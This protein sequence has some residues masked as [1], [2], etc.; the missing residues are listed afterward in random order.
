MSFIRF[1]CLCLILISPNILA[2][3]ANISVTE[4]SAVSV[5]P[6]NYGV[7]WDDRGTSILTRPAHG[8]ATI[9]RAADR[10]RYTPSPNY[11]GSD[12][13][14][15][16]TETFS[17]G[18]GE[19]LRLNI[20][21][22]V[23]TQ[24]RIIIKKLYV[25]MTV[26]CVNDAPTLTNLPNKSINEDS[27]TGNITFYISDPEK[28]SSSL[29]LSSWSS[30]TSLIPNGNIVLGGS[31]GTRTIKVTPVA[32]KYGSA[33]ISLRVSDGSLTKTDTFVVTVNAINDRPTISAISS[34][35]INE[36]ANTGN[37]GFSVADLETSAGSLLVTRT[38]SNTTLV[39]TASITLGGSGANRTVKVTP[40]ANKFGSVTIT[41]KV[42][43]GRLTASRAFVVTVRAV[44]DK[45]TVGGIAT[46]NINEDTSKAVSFTVSDLE[47]AAASLI[48]GKRSSN[49][50]LFPTS[51]IAIGGSGSNRTVT[52]T[53]L[54]NAYGQAVIYLDV[55]DGSATTTRSFIVN[56]A[57]V[58]EPPVELSM[59]E[60]ADLVIFPPDHGVT[61]SDYNTSVSSATN[62]VTRVNTQINKVIYTPKDN[63]CGSDSFT[64]THVDEPLP[65]QEP[66]NPQ[67]GIVETAVI[68]V[69]ITCVND[70][71]KISYISDQTFNE[72][73][74]AQTVTFRATDVDNPVSSLIVN[75]TNSNNVL[76]PS[77]AITF[78]VNGENR[79]ITF[80]PAA[81]KFGTSTFNIK[82]SD[83]S[84]LT[85]SNFNVII[86]SINDIPTVG[87]IATQNINEDTSKVISFT[88]NDI[89]TAATSLTIGKRS[90]NTALFPTSR[91]A[92]GGS[93]SN[94]TVTLTPVANAYGQAV[95]YLDVSD[96][97]ATTTISFT[98]NV[99]DVPEPPLTMLEDGIL[100]IFPPDHGVTYS[101]YN[102]SVSTAA[103]GLTRV[104]RTTNKVI[105]TPKDNYCGTDSFTITHVDEPLPDEEPVNGQA[106]TTETAVINVSVSCV[107]DVPLMEYIVDKVLD[108]D[109]A[110][111][112]AFFVRDVDNL[113]QDVTV[114][115]ATSN[116]TLFPSNSLNI[117]HNGENKTLTITPAA[118]KFG[119][120]TLTLTAS[121][122]LLSKTRSF[123]VTVNSVE[124]APIIEATSL[125]IF[126]EDTF[127]NLD[128]V[129]SDAETASDSLTITIA[130]D[131]EA[132]F[133]L[134]QL[135]L[136]GTGA[137][138]S[139]K[140]S[141]LT[142]QHGT[143]NITL[144]VF[145]GTFTTNH[146][147]AVTVNSIDD[148]PIF[149]LEAI[150]TLI[151]SQP[152]Q[153]SATATDVDSNITS[154][155]FSLDGK[156]WQADSSAP[157]QHNFG[158][159][160][161]GDH[162][163]RARVN[164]STGQVVSAP[165]A[166]F[167]VRERA[168]LT[169]SNIPDAANTRVSAAYNE[170]VG[171][172]NGNASVSGGAFSYSVPIVIAPGRNGIQPSISLNYSSQSGQGIAGLGWN[173]S[174][175][176]SISRCGEI[177][178]IDKSAKA[179]TF[180]N[181]DK[182]CY[183]GS[184]LISVD[185]LG[186]AV[187]EQSDYGLSSTYYK[188]ERNGSA[189]I[190]QLG[191]GINS[192][193]SYFVVTET[194]GSTHILGN[195][196]NSQI[197]TV[198]R[199]EPSAWLQQKTQDR[200]GNSID[201]DYDTT[202]PGNR[203]LKAIYYTGTA[204]ARGNRKVEFIYEDTASVT[205]YHWNGAKTSNKRLINILMK[206]ENNKLATWN[207]NY[208]YPT[209]IEEDHLAKLDSLSYCDGQSSLD[210]LTTSFTWLTKSF[211]YP[212]TTNHSLAHIRDNYAV[213]LRIRSDNDYDGDG[214]KD[215][216]IPM[217][218]VYLSSTNALVKREE[219]TEIELTQTVNDYGNFL[220]ESEI[221]SNTVN[222]SIDFNEDG[223]H[224]FI[225][226]NAAGDLVI[227]GVNDDASILFT[228][229]TGINATCYA[230]V[231]GSV[232][233]KYCSSHAVDFDGDGRSDLIVATNSETNEG[234][235]TITYKAYRQL[236]KEKGFSYA[237]EFT[238]SA[239]APLM[240][241]DVDGDGVLDI[242]PSA[243]HTDLVWYKVGY[244]ASTAKMTFTEKNVNFDV[245]V[246]IVHRTKP[247]RWVDLNGDGLSD[248]LTL[249]KTQPSDNFYT[250]YVAF[251]KGAGQF[252]APVSTNTEEL[253]WL[254]SG[255]N[256]AND[257]TY[258]G[259]SGYIY[260]GF[261]Q[262]IDYNGD[263]RQ[264]ILY[265]DRNRKVLSY[266]CHDY[267]SNEACDAIDGVDGPR[268]H[269]YDVW[270]W[271]VLITQ[272]D[273]VSFV[274]KEL[275]EVYGALAT[276]NT[277]DI[278]GD[279]R[280][281]FVSGIGFES[282]AIERRWS[283]PSDTT[284]E[285]AVFKQDET[286]NS[287]IEIVATEIGTK[288]TVSYSQLKDLYTLTRPKNSYPYINFGNTMRVVNSFAV[289]DGIGGENT[290]TYEYE[291]ARFH[292]AGR[293]FQGFKVINQHHSATNFL[294]GT[295][296]RTEFFD[297]FPWSG[298]VKSKTTE[299]DAGNKLSEYLV[300]QES[301]SLLEFTP[302]DPS[303]WCFYPSETI[304]N[305]FTPEKQSK[306]V[307]SVNTTLVKNERCQTKVSTK[308]VTDSN[309]ERETTIAQG[310]T[311]TD[312][313]FALPK[314]T[315]STATVTYRSGVL[316][317]ETYTTENTKT[318]SY[319][320]QQNFELMSTKVTGLDG[321]TS[322]T[323]FSEHNDYG[324]ALKV[325]KGLRWS[326]ILMSAGDYFVAS[327][328]NQLWNKNTTEVTNDPLTGVV[329]TATDINDIK[330]TNI[331]NFLGQV[332]ATSITKAGD[333]IAPSIYIS[334]QWDTTG[335][336][337]KTITRS[338][339]QP[340]VIN[341][342]DSKKRSVK[343]TSAG[344]LGNITSTVSYDGRGNI[345][346]QTSPTS[347][348]ATQT[349]TIFSGYDVLGR[350]ASKT[351]NDGT[352]NYISNYV[353]IDGLTTKITVQRYGASDLIMQRSY[354]SLKQLYRTVDAKQGVSEFAYNA[355][356][357]PILIQDVLGSQIK[358]HYNDLGQKEWF[359]DPNMGKW[360]F[361]YNEYGE[362][363]EQTDANGHTTGY[364][365]D[366]IGRLI[367]RD[368]REFI[369][370][371]SV[372][373]GR[374]YQTIYGAKTETFSYDNAGH[375]NKTVTQMDGLTFTQQ[376]AY[377]S[378]FNRLKGMMHASGETVAFDYDDN[379]YL[380]KDYQGY[381]D[382]SQELL[383]TIN[384]YNAF[385]AINQ[386]TFSN[387][388]VQNTYRNEAGMAQSICTNTSG[389]CNPFGEQY[390]AYGYDSMGNLA[391][392]HNQV[393]QFKET[394]SY[395]ELMRVKS[396][397]IYQEGF[398]ETPPPVILPPPIIP[399]PIIMSGESETVNDKNITHQATNFSL[400]IEKDIL[401]SSTLA[402]QYGYDA[403]GNITV[404]SDYGSN[405]QYGNSSKGLGGRA[406]PN[407]V[408]QFTKNG[409]T[410]QFT[411]DE[412]GNRKTG[413]GASIY[414]NSDNKPTSITRNGTT[415]TFSYGADGMRY[416]QV[417]DT[418]AA[419]ETT[420]YVGSVEHVINST[421]TVNR[422]YIGDHTIKVTAVSGSI[423]N[424]A[425]FQHILR[426]RL[427]G[428]DTLID[429][430]S[431]QVIQHRG[432]DVFGRPRDIAFGNNLL[433]DFKGVNR[434]FT[435]H[436]HLPELALIHMNGRVYDYN[437]GRFLSV[438][439]FLQFPENSQSANPYTYILNNPMSATDPTGYT[440]DN[441]SP[442]EEVATIN[443]GKLVE[444]QQEVK[445][446]QKNEEKEPKTS[447]R[448][449][450]S[451]NKVGT[452][453]SASS[454]RI[455]GGTRN[456]K[457]KTKKAGATVRNIDYGSVNAEYG[458]TTTDENGDVD[459]TEIV[460][461]GM[462]KEEVNTRGQVTSHQL[463]MLHMREGVGHSQ[464]LG[465]QALA[466]TGIAFTST[467]SMTSSVVN[468]IFA[469]TAVKTA[470]LN[471]SILLMEVTTFSDV[472][473]LKSFA[474]GNRAPHMQSL[475]TKGKW[476]K[477]KKIGIPGTKPKWRVG[478]DKL[479]IKANK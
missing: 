321:T 373:D 317:D 339:G 27:S 211:I 108:E 255:G 83:G 370:D 72:D 297:I 398:S 127:V 94:R 117:S 69:T 420:Y 459:T 262:F 130:T 79:S 128:V 470:I 204:T 20:E 4:D 330:T 457:G 174:A 436:E 115:I 323:Y 145:D 331:I 227:S 277:I 80:K 118:N 176:S 307:T 236:E 384:E 393:Q 142:D 81:H 206:I 342:F 379:G 268:F 29:S 273:G 343:Q 405:Y 99:A 228:Y 466:I 463:A 194:D 86:K 14:V 66:T 333:E 452:F 337:Y 278:N 462:C 190:Q 10:V 349:T 311:N 90:S 67:A 437:I 41:V 445:N 55:S 53:P 161:I 50:A 388:F 314:T 369:Y 125:K 215:L 139:L 28:S 423:G 166:S 35:T 383:R 239:A 334:N 126:D 63:Y 91:I 78:G 251:N 33:T 298:M 235:Y 92:I 352:V 391:F 113:S 387:G 218:G 203:Y 15:I 427:G 111:S 73:T 407:A 88:V 187:P 399:P 137:N 362:L 293:G 38:S 153:V 147:I 163:L 178:D 7:P 347:S 149:T 247:S 110:T 47:T 412:N 318:N 196:N 152:L 447:R 304:T 224:D 23:G 175:H 129:I 464:D 231:F 375:V 474:D 189:F 394:Y 193:N 222:G 449:R 415:S 322:T 263:G 285:F 395:D 386:Q 6:R 284:R 167:N 220:T 77:S 199:S 413:D 451:A 181:T 201:Y 45:P 141:P 324:Q 51:R 441:P 62:G 207:L 95:I 428:V 213:G 381:D 328:K 24:A 22:Q 164:T 367:N 183:N 301:P 242:A 25:Y 56:V 435:D 229:N 241:I 59:L 244:N 460:C 248:V 335:Y 123:A 44:N 191:G 65:D 136:S 359:D 448:D 103:N 425:P 340:E 234:N 325:Q 453:A 64:I 96:S 458:K 180:S 473:L 122:G 477:L 46:Q 173:L 424:Q 332:S 376:F 170:L 230:S 82:V 419:I 253:A 60:D 392:Q 450:R 134:S 416:K 282:D 456:T 475:L 345:L 356:G 403:A 348:Y 365:Y 168:L 212:K 89:E 238:A 326:K 225:Y 434:G 404:K 288:A 361:K 329:L 93:G 1:A 57:D 336:S 366:K 52:L 346:S 294:Y 259:P 371:V 135:I 472:Q 389:S 245:N 19:P 468:L 368:G 157:Y 18:G 179:A 219:L 8:S 98:V 54:A 292:I 358:A 312:L 303:V 188:T 84:E 315:T 101:D 476:G 165:V 256:I 185:K 296:T 310:Y 338:S 209:T 162:T 70:K 313:R 258:G 281:D 382:G 280:L 408:R 154:I 385:G 418:G 341:Y 254:V 417:K 104:D 246:N 11:C 429:A 430:N 396:A 274:V 2:A 102:T 107:N 192:A 290:T 177:Y 279:G 360:D 205:A 478:R 182:L 17:G 197:I 171:E 302:N 267:N 287:V 421:G 146:T 143:A 61:Y 276:M 106:I 160:S 410:H 43:D 426:D 156:S 401:P 87:A 308:K 344:F 406:G 377:D 39:P 75:I 48:I 217:E 32:N 138:R 257:P 469:S 210:C 471:S 286:Q 305:T 31:G 299:D 105:Y 148:L 461:G 85:E 439:P 233:V 264:D 378:Y 42:S 184:R 116:S 226:T 155:E 37:I 195:S 380:I 432:Y 40:A 289:E 30:N 216:Y 159:I 443:G 438:D 250:R 5:F 283:I 140:L 232:G 151:G 431:S 97:L 109:V 266:Q 169:I 100:S 446:G 260:E 121:D 71:P 374:L 275:D 124:D 291:N 150:D 467:Y 252:A 454:D 411:Y 440:Q 200:F 306:F 400:Y 68:N 58:A 354:N 300:R 133:P 120:A 269:Q 402:I 36:D 21:E 316:K 363:F 319:N 114:S 26:N 320:T 372:G 414:Y 76:L 16:E 12:Y 355:A 270:H 74:L 364:E 261:V 237:G 112:I 351:F 198:G 479:L 243:F 144:S 49:T 422:T 357:L 295:S 186:E 158:A 455:G 9:D 13:F 3:T 34:R 350:A 272:A 390:L 223:R 327:T 214:I 353:Y 119:T 465:L 208:S 172:I 397:L 442:T 444:K 132:L 265:P 221:S 249:H 271:N 240:P 409:T 309:I 131:K 202:V 433:N